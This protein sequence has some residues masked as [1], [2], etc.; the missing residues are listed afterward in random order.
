MVLAWEIQGCTRTGV[1]PIWD[2]CRIPLRGYSAFDYIGTS[3]GASQL[4]LRWRLGTR[5]GIAGFAGAGHTDNEAFRLS[6]NTTISSYGVGLR[7]M[8][9]KAKR[10]NLRLDFA[11][12]TDSEAIHFSIGEAF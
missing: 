2:G 3:S 1:V 9:L 11:K 10:I 6:D 4:E 8:V 12:S 5:W 7:F